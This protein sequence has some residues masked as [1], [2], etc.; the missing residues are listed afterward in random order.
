MALAGLALFAGLSAGGAGCSHPTGYVDLRSVLTPTGEGTASYARLARPLRI[1]REI[2]ERS[3]LL[4]VRVERLETT[5]GP[6]RLERFGKPTWVPWH[7]YHPLVKLPVAVTIFP[8][9]F[10]AFHDPTAYSGGEWTRWDYFHDVGAWFNL[11]SAVPSG[12]RVVRTE[13]ERI[14]LKDVV[15]VISQ[16]R[17]P[18]VGRAVTL[19]LDGRELARG[20]SDAEGA[21]QFD[22][23]PFLTA[24]K[25]QADH[26]L[27]IVSLSESGEEAELSQTLEGATVRRFIENRSP[28]PQPAPSA[29]SRP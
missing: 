24:E 2:S 3:A 9:F 14:L 17:A 26:L 21:V 29:P 8:P 7:W 12:G 10:L 13:E 27:R 20:V 15:T 23:A 28:A 16:R 25:A 1:T 6:A 11:C 19:S 4:E 22:L 18:V 5:T